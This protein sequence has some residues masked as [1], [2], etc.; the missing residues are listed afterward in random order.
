MSSIVLDLQQEVL[1][2]E[3]DVLNALRKAHLIASK[4]KLKEFDKWIMHE[5]NGYSVKEQDNIPEYRKVNGKLKAW[6]PYRGWTSV[7]FQDSKMQ[8]LLCTKYL[9]SSIGEILE[10]YNNSDGPVQMSYPVDIERKIDEMCSAPFPTN[11]SLHISTHVLKSI[12]DQVQNCLLEWTIKLENEGILGEGMRFNKDETNLAKKVP[13][14][15][16]NYYGTV[17]NGDIQQSQVV[18]GD[19]NNISFNYQQT[20][21]LIQKIK[22]AIQNE[23]I[24]DEDRETA[25]EL[26]TD[27]E[28]KIIN[29][30]KPAIIKAALNGLKDFLI[31]A[32]ANIAGALIMQYL[33]QQGI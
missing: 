4:L 7:I 17:V 20:E 1:K 15:I 18:S 33:Q 10:L 28:S 14:T 29:Q 12:V 3:C 2:P 5:L 31:G 24:S 9:G 8:S 32:G 6:N 19:H 27:A 30:K 23:Q 21:N 11:Y 22:E 16:Y 25:D 26:I 13:Q